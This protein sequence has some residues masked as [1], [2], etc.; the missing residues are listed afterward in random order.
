MPQINLATGTET[1]SAMLKA[2]PLKTKTIKEGEKN[3]PKRNN[4]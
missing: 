1:I 3:E 2:K 4:D